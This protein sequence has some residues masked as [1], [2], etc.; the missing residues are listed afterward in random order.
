MIPRPPRSTRT[1]TLV[2]YTTLFRSTLLSDIFRRRRGIIAR[3]IPLA[4]ILM[5]IEF[6]ILLHIRAKKLHFR[7]IFQ[8]D[9][10]ILEDRR[11]DLVLRVELF[12]ESRADALGE[13]RVDALEA[14]I[15]DIFIA[16]GRDI[17]RGGLH[18]SRALEAG[19]RPTALGF[20]HF[21]GGSYWC[22]RSRG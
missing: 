21:G 10:L 2:P 15:A 9:E 22:R 14:R 17:R 4:H 19:L 11:M 8:T 12:S 3:K 18:F 7:A 6:E 5:E 20:S 1:D 13:P 16:N